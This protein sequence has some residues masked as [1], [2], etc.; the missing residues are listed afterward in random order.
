MRRASAV[1]V[2]AV[3]AG[4]G[5]PWWVALGP[6]PALAT[7]S[8][9]V[10]DEGHLRFVKGSGS[11]LLDEG[12]VTG[13]FPGWVKVRFTYNG[14][15]TVRASLT[16]YGGGGTISAR[17]SGRLSSPTSLNPSFRGRMYATGGSGRYAHLHGS[18]EMFGV[19][20]RRT[21]ELTVQAI[22]D[23]SY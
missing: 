9:N 12:R 7:R 1:I 5:V 3:S 6:D 18:G 8:L 22:G 13:T 16:I 14:E 15:P 4:I 17:G 23:L 10:R 21:Y 20:H 2:V 11:Q 19:F